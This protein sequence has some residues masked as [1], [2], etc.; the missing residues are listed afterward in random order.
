MKTLPN[1]NQE[2][3]LLFSVMLH[4]V[5]YYICTGI[6]EKPPVS[7]KGSV[8]KSHKTE[9]KFLWYVKGCVKLHETESE[10]IWTWLYEMSNKIDYCTG[11]WWSYHVNGKW[12]IV[13]TCC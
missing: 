11:K 12:Q 7:I 1:S 13:T 8:D 4:C 9:M 3:I 10:D 6:S 2:R 5:F